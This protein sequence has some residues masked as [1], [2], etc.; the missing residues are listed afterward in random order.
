[1]TA[2]E[3]IIEHVQS[4]LKAFK[5]DTIRHS[6]DIVY[7]RA[8]TIVCMERVEQVIEGIIESFSRTASLGRLTTIAHTHDLLAQLVNAWKDYDV[9]EDLGEGLTTF[10]LTALE[11]HRFVQE[12]YHFA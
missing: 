12:T 1:M 4:E 10:V 11:S 6:P 7:E 3:I 8:Y 5:A 9:D 2:Q